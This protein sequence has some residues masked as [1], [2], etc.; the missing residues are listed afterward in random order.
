MKTKFLDKVLKNHSPLCKIF[1]FSDGD[2]RR[3]SC[4]KDG[5]AIEKDVLASGFEWLLR[6]YEW[7]GKNDSMSANSTAYKELEKIVKRAV[8]N[9]MCRLK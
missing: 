2:N 4:G 1:I 8:E 6:A 5:A 9:K 3:C 7:F